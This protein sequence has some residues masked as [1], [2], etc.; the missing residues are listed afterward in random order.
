MVKVHVRFLAYGV[1]IWHL[2]MQILE[3]W[4]RD[5]RNFLAQ[6]LLELRLLRQLP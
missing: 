5:L 4:V 6:P 2:P 3:G 1:Q